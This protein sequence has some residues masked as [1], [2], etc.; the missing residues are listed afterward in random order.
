MI[1]TVSR[2]ADLDAIADSDLEPRVLVEVQTSMR[3]HGIRL[4][5]LGAVT[6]LLQRVR[7][8]VEHPSAAAGGGPLRRGRGPHPR[9]GRR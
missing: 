6:P 8:E 1:T 5:H 9:G 3:R 4:D 2:L 7:F